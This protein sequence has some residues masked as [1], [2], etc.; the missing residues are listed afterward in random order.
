MMAGNTDEEAYA[1]WN[2]GLEAIEPLIEYNT[3][4]MGPLSGR[5]MTAL[6]FLVDLENG[7]DWDTHTPQVQESVHYSRLLMASA[8]KIIAAA[9]EAEAGP[10]NQETAQAIREALN[11]FL[12][13]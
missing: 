7:Y 4:L 10:E 9:Q 5:L 8:L 2:R 12:E 1:E 3:R 6:S 13:E 11:R